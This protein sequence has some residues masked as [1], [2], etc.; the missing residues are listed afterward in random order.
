MNN[1]NLKFLPINF[2]ELSLKKYEELFLTCFPNSKKFNLDYLSWLYIENPEGPA[3]G[4]DVYDGDFL[5]A[6]YVCIPVSFSINGVVEKS[7]LSLNT[8][9]H[10]RYQGIGLF[11]KLASM[12]Y[13]TAT[14]LGYSSIFG[15]ANAN[16]TH[17]FV[18]KLGFQLLGQLE[19]K[20]GFGR[21]N[22]DFSVVKE[23]YTFR[24]WNAKSLNWRCSNPARSIECS[25]T[26][27]GIIFKAGIFNKIASVIAELPLGNKIPLNLSKFSSPLHIF[28]GLI[29]KQMTHSNLYFDIPQKLRPS[30]LN[31]IYLS[32]AG[33]S[34][35]LYRDNFLLN[36]LDFDAF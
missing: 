25:M 33:K 27:N 19:A 34:E 9:T 32:L 35:I 13:A 10:P 31:L 4:F 3:I 23:G 17:G 5:A 18:R 2:D 26:S 28:I 29:P 15:I 6:H 30:P 14:N 21:L 36:F 22:I 20:I 11:T 1:I 8:A 16:S 24:A 12:T 7:L